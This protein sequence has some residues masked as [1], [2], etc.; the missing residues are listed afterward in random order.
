M[1]IH[2][3]VAG[4]F[5]PNTPNELKAMVTKFL[6]AAVAYK[7]LVVPKAIIVPHAGYI[8]SGPIAAS[9]YA[10]L[11]NTKEHKIT[12]VVIMA[13][14]HRSYID[15][16]ATTTASFYETPLGQIPIATAA[17]SAITD[18]LYVQM[19]DDAFVTE[20]A[21]EVQLPFL[22]IMLE[23]FAIV[24]LLVGKASVSQVAKVLSELWDGEQTLIIIS[25]DLSHY[26][27]YKTAQNIDQQTVDA[28]INCNLHKITSET[29]CGCLPIK[30][31]LSVAAAKS[32]Q[33]KLL[34]LRNSGDTAGSKD[35]VVGYAAFHVLP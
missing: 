18:L 7:D 35:A 2:P 24:P 28:I 25:S 4:M 29:A 27:D 34:D 32:M 1:I 17:M 5:Y 21:I 11:A 12:Q 22:Q 33:I 13:P 14:A 30:G 26:H 8:Y 10:C 9:A 23:D 6:Q 19:N 16:I 31:M 3:A 20:H 15:G